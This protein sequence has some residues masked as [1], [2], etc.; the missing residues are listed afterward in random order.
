[1]SSKDSVSKRESILFKAFDLF[2]LHRTV[3]C[4][5]CSHQVETADGR[6]K[7]QLIRNE[8]VSIF[9]DHVPAELSIQSASDQCASFVETLEQYAEHAL[10]AKSADFIGSRMKSYLKSLASEP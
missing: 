3:S 1:M 4:P 9:K 10:G 5:L 7:S 2:R 6:K 8:I